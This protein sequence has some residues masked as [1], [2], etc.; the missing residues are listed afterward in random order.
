VRSLGSQSDAN[1]KINTGVY[2]RL[3]DYSINISTK[4]RCC[5]IC[6]RE[7][8][9]LIEDFAFLDNRADRLKKRFSRKTPRV[10]FL[11]AAALLTGLLASVVAA[12]V[13]LQL[14]EG[15]FQYILASIERSFVDQAAR[16]D[17][18]FCLHSL[19]IFIIY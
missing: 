5:G 10:S 18:S 3:L 17:F 9:N 2:D 12:I 4:G 19:T 13:E 14:I 7:E 8:E 11:L 16:F 15:V 1:R 6:K